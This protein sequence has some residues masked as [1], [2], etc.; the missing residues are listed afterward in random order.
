MA[1][2]TVRPQKPL[3][4]FIEARI[5]EYADAPTPPSPPPSPFSPLS[6]PLPRTLSLP[7]L[8]PSP[9]HR[10]MIIEAD[11]PPR[12]RARL[13]APSRRFEI[14]ESLVAAAARHPGSALT[15]GTELGFMTALEEVKE[16]VTDIP[17]R[18]RERRYYRHMAMIADREAMYAWQAWTHFMDSIYE[19]HVEIR[20]LQAETRVLQQQ[21][22]DDHD[23]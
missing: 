8:L 10:D 3:S 16:S 2:K 23:M 14:G 6:S 17:A 19:S 1:R 18:H 11:M 21:R 15:R 4:A 12:K 5:A 20:G 13:T 22:R 9:T 7:F